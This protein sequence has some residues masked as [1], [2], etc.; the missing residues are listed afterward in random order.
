MRT[1]PLIIKVTINP[2]IAIDRKISCAL[3]KMKVI[4][5]VFPFEEK[6]NWRQFPKKSA[7]N[8]VI[9]LSAPLCSLFFLNWATANKLNKSAIGMSFISENESRSKWIHWLLISDIVEYKSYI[10]F[11]E[12]NQSEPS[13]IPVFVYPHP[14]LWQTGQ[15]ES[16][17]LSPNYSLKDASAHQ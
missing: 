1:R 16:V 3:T 17:Y 11:V 2:N 9:P 7:A 14:A 4:E 5:D 13:K 12:V 6:R 10:K 15:K 8:A